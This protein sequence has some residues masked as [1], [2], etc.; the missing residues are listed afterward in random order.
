MEAFVEEIRFSE[1][2]RR[3]AIFVQPTFEP[4]NLQ[5][6]PQQGQ[7]R[8]LAQLH[9]ARQKPAVKSRQIVF[10][11]RQRPRL[12]LHLRHSRSHPT[13]RQLELRSMPI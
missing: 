4:E 10:D 6:K 9:Q 12:P 11:Q 8:E 5:R 1:L 2:V 13:N 3:N 7:A